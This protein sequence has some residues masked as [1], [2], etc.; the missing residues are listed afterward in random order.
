[1]FCKTYL[2]GLL[3]IFD[4]IVMDRVG[5][6]LPTM[7]VKVSTTPALLKPLPVL[8]GSGGVVGP[9]ADVVAGDLFH[10]ELNMVNQGTETLHGVLFYV[11]ANGTTYS[12][13]GG[14]QFVSG[15]KLSDSMSE[16]KPAS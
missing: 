16:T 9:A 6:L 15:A 3:C 4:I 14:G 13:A 1:M 7:F 12:V 2:K 11:A 5:R 10:Y 8:V